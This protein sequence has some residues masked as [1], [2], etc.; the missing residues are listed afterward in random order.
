MNIKKLSLKFPLLLALIFTNGAYA[1]TASPDAMVKNTANEVLE[2]LNKD[3]TN[4][5]MNKMGKLVEEKIATKFDFNL[6][7]KIVLGQN[8]NTASK[9]QQDQFI[10]EFRSLLVRTYSSALSKYRNQTIEYQPLH[11]ELGDTKVK[12]KTQIIQ[13]GGPAIPLDYSLEKIEGTWK[14]YDVIID[15]LSLVAIYRGQFADEVKQNGIDSLIQKLIE[16]NKQLP[17]S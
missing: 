17:Q 9:G 1:D 12:V 2:V 10:V 4:S 7:S 14:V 13:P 11:A 16:K 5:N 3:A 8:W 6:M 15:G